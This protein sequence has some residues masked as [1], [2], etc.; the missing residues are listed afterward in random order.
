MIYNKTNLKLIFFT[1][2]ATPKLKLK[3]K[4][5]TQTLIKSSVLTCSAIV[6]A[7]SANAS[8]DYGPAHWVPNCGQYYTSGYGHKFVVIHDMEG[9]YASTI[10][11]FQNCGTTA[12]IHY[13]TN[14]KQDTSTDAAAGDVTQM[15]S[16]SNYAFHVICWNRY[17]LGTEH[18]GFESNPAW[19]TDAQYNASGD[20]QQHLCDKFGIA[21]DRNHVVGHNAKSSSAW[22]T[23]ATAN[24]G[25]NATC[26]THTDPGIYWDWTKFMAIV[27]GN[28]TQTVAGPDSV[29]SSSGR[30]DTVI[31]GGG[32]AI[33][34]KYWDSSTGWSGFNNIGGNSTS[35]PSV[36][37]WAP[38]RI[39]AFTRG[40]DDALW[41]AYWTS[42]S[43]SG[44]SS[45]GGVLSASP[46][47]VSWAANR[48]D[49]VVR[50]GGNN[51]YHKYWDGS[52]WGPSG[53]F[54]NL[55]G[56]NVASAPSISSRGAGMLDAFYRGTDNALWHKW[57]D[58]TGWHGPESLGGNIVGGPA[59]VSWGLSSARIDIV[60]RGPNSDILHTWW[61]NVGGWHGWES[62]NGNLI[63]D[64]GISSRGVGMLDIFAAGTDKALWH[65]WFDSGGWHAWQSLGGTLQ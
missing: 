17:C 55:G 44:W 5:K 50:G 64:P 34:H 62:L 61:E 65:K 8:S 7:I 28:T 51:L 52:A 48:I 11:F 38:G 56:G 59:S 2:T 13:C 14:G 53:G 19:Y 40:T 60:S 58:G 31:R 46:A 6:A 23:Y 33:F 47:S 18:E 37:S 43:W 49:V 21:K 29:S 16:E 12:S 15:V 32:N 26:N 24:F 4:T 35:G 36:C 25:I 9:Y 1:N 45:I 27:N 39:D 22:V 10:S 20:L 42:G 63:S 3:M 30:I 54:E 41:H 57:F